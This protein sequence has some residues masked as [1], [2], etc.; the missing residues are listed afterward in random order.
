MESKK[1]DK[2]FNLFSD[3]LNDSYTRATN[4]R[5]KAK[6]VKENTLIK[7]LA[8][9][10]LASMCSLCLF[11]FATFIPF[12]KEGMI[13]L[14]TI[15]PKEAI[16]FV[17][18][19][20]LAGTAAILRNIV[21]K[22]TKAKFK[23]FSKSKTEDEKVEEEMEYTIEAEKQTVRNLI[24]QKS[25]EQFKANKE[26]L[27]TMGISYDQGINSKNQTL[28]E[29]KATLEDMQNDLK[30]KY[31]KLYNNVTKLVLQRKMSDIKS[32]NPA[33]IYGL[34]GAIAG[35]MALFLPVCLVP[36]LNVLFN[37]VGGLI[38]FASTMVGSF[39]IGFG[40]RLKRNLSIKRA[41]NKINATLGEDA[42]PKKYDWNKGCELCQAVD[43]L[44]N[45]IAEKEI[46]VENQK[47]LVELLEEQRI[48]EEK[49]KSK[50][51]AKTVEFVQTEEETLDEKPQELKLQ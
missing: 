26:F 38:T 8:D 23:E 3:K 46:L 34:M 35:E 11:T 45:S 47:R 7:K 15:I 6:L 33:F 44:K 24:M 25:M 48:E 2:T 5:S 22:D 19:G 4:E 12:V 51:K 30:S 50:E 10:G 9:I 28:E 49:E 20:I 31:E 13:A 14:G 42:L 18:C 37:S 41:Y 1:F 27:D 40:T 32:G 29:A 16:S 17:I 43:A 39:G 36:E 21:H